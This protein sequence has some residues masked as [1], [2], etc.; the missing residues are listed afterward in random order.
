MTYEIRQIQVNRLYYL[1]IF[2]KQ[3]L[4]FTN[5]RTLQTLE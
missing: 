3:T 4:L 2:S 1:T 5:Q